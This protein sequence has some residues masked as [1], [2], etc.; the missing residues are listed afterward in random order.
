MKRCI[1]HIGSDKTGTSHIQSFL[2]RN[3]NALKQAGWIYPETPDAKKQA[4]GRILSGNGYT[5]F[6]AVNKGEESARRIISSYP[7]ENILISSEAL[8]ALDEGQLRLLARELSLGG[9]D[10][11]FIFYVR[12]PIDYFVSGVIQW[13]KRNGGTS[14][15]LDALKKNIGRLRTIGATDMRRRVDM[16]VH[17]VGRNNAVIRNYSNNSFKFGALEYDFLD[18]MGINHTSNFQLVSGRINPSLTE[19]SLELILEIN[20]TLGDGDLSTKVSDA[21][22]QAQAEVSGDPVRVPR[23]IL[24]QAAK[25]FTEDIEYMRKQYGLV[26]IKS[27]TEEI[28]RDHEAKVSASSYIKLCASVLRHIAS[29]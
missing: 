17:A 20:R 15:P 13:A 29:K 11:L 25:E 22:M 14:H 10:P 21:M 12:A 2:A 26:D 19:Q 23:E 8:S 7:N 6:L 5:L 16:L 4:E 3:T 1:L 28:V 18:A 24:E 27:Y 9:Y